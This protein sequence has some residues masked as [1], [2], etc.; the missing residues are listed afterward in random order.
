MNIAGLFT[1]YGPAHGSGQA[2]LNKLTG[3]VRS[4]REV[5]EISR[6]GWGRVKRFSNL[7]GRAGPPK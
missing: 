3:R 4:G 2:V 6:V 1:G 7:T 5:F